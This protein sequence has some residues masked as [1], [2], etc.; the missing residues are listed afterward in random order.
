MVI[1]T[2]LTNIKVTFLHL[3]MFE[4]A[5]DHVRFSLTEYGVFQRPSMVFLGT[6]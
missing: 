5:L 2:P 4:I 6:S 3:R 1:R